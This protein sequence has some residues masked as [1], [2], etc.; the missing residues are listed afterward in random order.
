MHFSNGGYREVYKGVHNGEAIAVK[1][2]IA[3]KGS[4]TMNSKLLPHPFE[5]RA[6]KHHMV[7]WL[8]LR[9]TTSRQL[10]S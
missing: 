1:K 7:N 10:E 3:F 8:L 2:L 4:R 9:N 6:L 5:A